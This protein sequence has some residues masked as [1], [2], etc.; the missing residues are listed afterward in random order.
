MLAEWESGVF[1]SVRPAALM[2]FGGLF[3]TITWSRGRA[4]KMHTELTGMSTASSVGDINFG[5]DKA[6]R[7]P[8]ATQQPKT[9]YVEAKKG[10]KVAPQRQGEAGA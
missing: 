3:Q 4:E 1:T 8:A 5:D 7:L 2:S 9:V 10:T 6:K